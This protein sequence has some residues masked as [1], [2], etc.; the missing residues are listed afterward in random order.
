M[1]PDDERV[2]ELI[3]RMT[4]MDFDRVF[5]PRKEPLS[6]PKYKL[7]TLEELE[8]VGIDHPVCKVG[9]NYPMCACVARD[10]VIGCLS[11]GRSVRPSVCT[12]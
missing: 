2:Q 12:K 7:M 6:L 5:A 1:G 3:L 11:L 4:G 10:R 8:K 9:I